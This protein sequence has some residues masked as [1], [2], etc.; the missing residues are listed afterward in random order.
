MPA[1]SISNQELTSH[2]R[3][4]P[5]ASHAPGAVYL[6]HPD[7]HKVNFTLLLQPGYWFHG[8]SSGS[9]ETWPEELAR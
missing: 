1:Y 8:Q 3:S 9:N 6:E 4:R 7:R 5:W 2:I